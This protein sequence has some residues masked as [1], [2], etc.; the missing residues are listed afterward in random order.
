MNLNNKIVRLSAKI[1]LKDYIN[2]VSAED[3]DKFLGEKS[4]SLEKRLE[5]NEEVFKRLKNR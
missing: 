4:K 3:Y 2:A 5:E 1:K